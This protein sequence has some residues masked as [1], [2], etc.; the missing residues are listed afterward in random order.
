MTTHCSVGVPLSGN[1][2]TSRGATSHISGRKEGRKHNFIAPSPQR[3]L[4]SSDSL[5][6][7]HKLSMNTVRA[8]ARKAAMA[9][10]AMLPA[11]RNMHSTPAALSDALFVVCSS[12]SNDSAKQLV[13]LFAKH[14]STNSTATRPRTTQ[15]SPSSSM[16]KI[17]NASKRS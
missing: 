2:S 8:L 3:L 5:P 11:A 7:L 13:Y 12:S 10:S 9:S 16:Q 14:I 15:R 17:R 1:S 6:S 4:L